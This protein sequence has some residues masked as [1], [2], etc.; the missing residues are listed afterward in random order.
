[1]S[2]RACVYL[3]FHDEENN[4]RP[5]L[6]ICGPTTTLGE[7]QRDADICSKYGERLGG[8]RVFFEDPITNPK[9]EKPT[10]S[11]EELG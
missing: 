1:M 10:I 3:D 9:K 5:L 7:L 6:R 4:Q 8:I 11:K 2:S